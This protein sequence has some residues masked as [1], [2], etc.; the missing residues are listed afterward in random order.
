[1]KR[2]YIQ[3]AIQIINLETTP[4]LGILSDGMDVKNDKVSTA[5]SSNFEELS[6]KKQAG[7]P[8]WD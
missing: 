1:M 7:N 2:T 6:N 3:P 8:I 4:L 5:G